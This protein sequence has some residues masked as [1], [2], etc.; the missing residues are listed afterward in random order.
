MKSNQKPRVKADLKNKY[1]SMP[2]PVSKSLGNQIDS[3]DSNA[4]KTAALNAALA[5]YESLRT[6]MNHYSERIDKVASI[7]ITALFAVVGYMLR[8][9]GGFSP[10]AYLD[11]IHQ[12]MGL[13]LLFLAIPILNSILLTRVGSFYLGVLA[14]SQYTHYETAQF[15]KQITGVNCMTWDENPDLYVKKKWIKSRSIGQG[16][17]VLTAQGILIGVLVEMRTA[18]FRGIVPLALFTASTLLVATSVY[19]FYSVWLA[20]RNFHQNLDAS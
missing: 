4:N 1:K 10:R 19:T 18:A 13:S 17:F 20:G 12:S 15:V 9:D 8:P 3:T 6:E 7:Y 11:R 5:E 2:N 16:L 14:I